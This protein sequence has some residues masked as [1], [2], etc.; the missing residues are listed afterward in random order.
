MKR[1]LLITLVLIG[2]VARSDTWT[3]GKGLI[4]KSKV[5]RVD[6]AGKLLHLTLEGNVSVVSEPQGLTITSDRMQFNA[7]PD[8]K[9][10]KAY[11]VQNATAIGHV[12]VLKTATTATGV[13]TTR[14]EGPKGE[15]TAGI[16]ESKVTMSGP[17]RI[18]TVDELKHPTMDATGSSG[19]AIL[20]PL[21]QTNLDN[22]MRKATMEG[23]VSLMLSQ[24]DAKTKKTIT[25]HTTSDHMVLENLPNGRR[26][27]LTGS[28]HIV[29]DNL[30]E[31][32]NAKRAVF[33]LEK[34]GN[35]HLE[36]GGDR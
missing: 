25:V 13:K 5:S 15:Y 29:G 36:T 24:V 10:S 14:V 22:A 17:M 18:G 3:D 16:S 32:S 35:Y 4:A 27:T 7:V 30:G 34:N 9:N 2:S 11:L 21:K 26:V 6:Q 23:P 20:E 12:T 8:P 28:V 33:V 19:V 31:M 1:L